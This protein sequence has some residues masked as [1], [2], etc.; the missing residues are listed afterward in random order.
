MSS[1][2]DAGTGLEAKHESRIF[3]P[4]FTTKGAG[5]GTGLGLAVV[6]G[7]LKH[8]KGSI[9]VK[10]KPGAGASFQIYLPVMRRMD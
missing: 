6:Y 4:F 1:V 7:I 2:E 10:S 9:Q 5:R 8:H 3:E